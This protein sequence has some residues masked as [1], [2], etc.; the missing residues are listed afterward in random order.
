MYAIDISE[1]THGNTEVFS[2]MLA[3]LDEV[4]GP[5]VSEDQRSSVIKDDRSTR[6]YVVH[7][8]G[9]HYEYS[10]IRINNDDERE[11]ELPKHFHFASSKAGGSKLYT[12]KVMF[13]A[14][15]T[16]AVEFKLKW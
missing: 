10:N 5:Q 9:W 7:G 1:M 3:W 14:D 8:T 15:A 13:I 4:V 12:S 16:R 6:T 11:F 2:E